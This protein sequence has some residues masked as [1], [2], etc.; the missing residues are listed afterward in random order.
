MEYRQLGESGLM[1]S[2]IGLGTITFAREA[3]EAASLRILDRFVDLGGNL[4]DTADGY[5][6]GGSEELIGRWI[7][8]R[9]CRDRVVLATKVYATTGPGPNDGGLARIHIQRAAEASLRRLQT[10]VIDL[11]QIQRWDSRCPIEETAEALSD[12]VR[13]GKVRYIGC[14]NVTG[15]QLSRF[16]HVA[17][18]NHWSRPV[19]VQ[20]VYNALNRG[21]ELELLPLCEDQGLGVM[22]YNP[23]AGG[24]LTGKYRRAEPMPSGAR[25]EAFGSYFERYYTEQA[26]DVVERF[27]RAAEARNAT[28]AQLALAWVLAE[29]RM[30]CPIV[31][32]RN[33]EQFADTAGGLQIALSPSERATIPAVESGRWVGQ[34]PVYDRRD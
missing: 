5:S 6:A 33:V 32:A 1:V 18:Q 11:Y 17:R 12:L 16:L 3:N 10:E 19:S 25:L 14:S 24:M 31:G 8:A 9:G 27:V 22:T 4:I 7:K 34:D 15:W 20:P 28:P 2:A 30:T 29:P 26:L 23:L 21:A 13:Q